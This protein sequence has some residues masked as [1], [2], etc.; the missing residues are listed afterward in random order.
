VEH[1]LITG[2]EQFLPFAQSCVR[3]LKKLGL[4]YADQ[5]Y[6]IDGVSI[7]VRVEPG[8]EY[9]RIE[10]GDGC[11]FDMDSGVVELPAW[12]IYAT[13]ILHYVGAAADY[14][15]VFREPKDDR[16][17]HDGKQGQLSGEVTVKT[18]GSAKG[19]ILPNKSPAASY[20]PGDVYSD[21]TPPVASPNPADETLKAKR[22]ASSVGAAIYTGKCR[23]YVQAITGT[24][25]YERDKSGKVVNTNE[26]VPLDGRIQPY[27]APGTKPGADI[28]NI[29]I[30]TGTGIYLDPLT[31]KHWMFS[32]G[33]EGV[34]IYPL[35]SSPCGEKLRKHL[36]PATSKLNPI[37]QEHLET[38][39]LARS[40]PDPLRAQYA[41]TGPQ[42]SGITMGYSW[43]WAWSTPVADMVVNNV[44]SNVDRDSFMVSSHY[45]ITMTI[46]DGKWSARLSTIEPNKEW[47]V[48]RE[49]WP[50][51]EPLAG[52]GMR[53][54]TG[55]SFDPFGDAPFY[56]FYV[57]DKIHICRV[58]VQKISENLSRETTPYFASE[59]PGTPIN[60]YGYSRGMEEGRAS[61]ELYRE[62]WICTISCG[63]F[64]SPTGYRAYHHT[65]IGLRIH[66]KVKKPAPTGYPG[67]GALSSDY[68]E[69]YFTDLR[70][71]TVG[72]TPYAPVYEYISTD[73]P[74]RSTRGIGGFTETRFLNLEYRNT[75]FVVAVPHG[76]AEALFFR[77]TYRQVNDNTA[78][79]IVRS[80]GDGPDW[81]LT[82]EI[83]TL[84]ASNQ[85]AKDGQ[86]ES[87][88]DLYL[89]GG[90]PGFGH[91]AEV[92]S[93]PKHEEK[94]NTTTTL[95]G[96]AGGATA[97]L[98][99]VDYHIGS[100][101]SVSA[102]IYTK[103]SAS[104]TAPIVHTPDLMQDGALAHG[105]P[106]IN[107]PADAPFTSFVGW[108]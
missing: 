33:G 56:V 35:I 62:Y 1:R 94:I 64:T 73:H 101:I 43:H 98:P 31:G 23:L 37:D 11:L 97:L 7:K 68:A 34:Q 106:N 26:F 52:G 4:P 100:Q 18:S 107:M 79:V 75:F 77:S 42:P 72:G 71:G 103:S 82:W 27:I 25:L 67:D 29:Y 81:T 48:N 89:W 53:K 6:E 3:K 65:S 88:N 58:K 105:E 87:T 44:A 76:D 83:W 91:T 74:Y 46:A 85:I 28:G 38:Y 32:V 61:D 90:G 59:T 13:G 69:G 86:I 102:T 57:R 95:L 63:D 24:P 15:D 5:S 108:V 8:H 21:D 41:K 2:G 99:E 12:D 93:E 60:N 54:I 16:L 66:D 84:G 80:G 92:T 50:I 20:S 70:V 39:I 40:R 9:I 49:M 78:T 19:S 47:A 17:T 55:T 14:N 51:M 104:E 45:R 36:I 10:G 30:D 96:R 22:L